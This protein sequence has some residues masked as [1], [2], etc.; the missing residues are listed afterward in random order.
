[1]TLLFIVIGWLVSLFFAVAA[2]AM[3]SM[4][5][6][7]QAL[8]LLVA[9]LVF[10][11]PL[12]TYLGQTTGWALPWW[13]RGLVTVVLLAGVVAV[14]VL[15]PATS[16]YKSPAVEAQ[17][18]QLYDAK[19]AKWPVPYADVFVDTRYGRIH[20]IVS[21][22]EGAPPVMLINASAVAAWSWIA[23]VAALAADHRVYAIDNIG[24]VGKNV[25]TD[26]NDIPRTGSQIAAYY[27]E[28]ADKL[29]IGRADVVG[30][31]VGGYIAT[32]LA[33][34]A[35]GRVR[36][37]VLLGPMGYGDTTR[38][39]LV[40]TLAQAFPLKPVQRWALTGR[41]ATASG[42]RRSSAN[43]SAWCSTAR[44]RSRSRRAH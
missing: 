26:I 16:I 25:Q 41:L 7:T 10:L 39:I 18:D 43:G 2:Y 33:L 28:I 40:M 23:N 3:Y 42:W 19:L 20:V 15:N 9:C 35:P 36:K 8:L 17:F 34:H 4:G 32:M 12:R 22:P 13:G 21:G 27:G 44:C 29:A 31:S 37:L 5:G 14:T 30:A 24:E 11:P 1:M 38:T 6:R